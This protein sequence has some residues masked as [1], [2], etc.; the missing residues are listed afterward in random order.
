MCCGV[1]PNYDQYFE[2]LGGEENGNYFEILTA[3]VQWKAASNIEVIHFQK[4]NVHTLS[5]AT[6]VPSR[7]YTTVSR[8]FFKAKANG[9]KKKRIGV[10][11]WAQVSNSE[12]AAAEGSLWSAYFKA[13]A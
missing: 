13:F 2:A 8:R 1:R 9:L 10:L 3:K 11:R 7:L 4:N 12:V 5:P 6:S